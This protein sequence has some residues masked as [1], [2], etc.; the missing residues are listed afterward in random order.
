M[1][2]SNTTS[3]TTVAYHKQHQYGYF[4]EPRDVRSFTALADARED[5]NKSMANELSR[6]ACDDYQED[7]MKHMRQME[8]KNLGSLS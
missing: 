4:A 7:I 8:V 1:S 6:Q 5:T 3:T 2:V